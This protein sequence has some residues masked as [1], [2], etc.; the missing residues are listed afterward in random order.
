[1]SGNRNAKTWHIKELNLD[2]SRKL[3][4]DLYDA[5]VNPKVKPPAVVN[6]L[7]GYKRQIDELKQFD[8]PDFCLCVPFGRDYY[9]VGFKLLVD[10]SKSLSGDL[11]TSFSYEPWFV[12]DRVVDSLFIVPDGDPFKLASLDTVVSSNHATL[13]ASSLVENAKKCA[14]NCVGGVKLTRQVFD[15]V[16]NSYKGFIDDSERSALEFY[17]SLHISRAEKIMVDGAEDY[18]KKSFLGLLRSRM[19]EEVA[20][21][22][23]WN[24]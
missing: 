6:E 24:Y 4:S 18:F 3:G 14:K 16:L 12:I 22:I 19:T 9:S 17:C 13:I 23:N 5:I 1:M 2:I 11:K 20:K 7:R 10:S 8:W 21:K 15:V